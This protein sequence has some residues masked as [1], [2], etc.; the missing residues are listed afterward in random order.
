MITAQRL[1][2]EELREALTP[3]LT[4]ALASTN[5]I[6]SIAPFHKKVAERDD[7]AVLDGVEKLLVR[8]ADKRPAAV[9]LVSSPQAPGLVARG[10]QRA[11]EAKMLLGPQLGQVIL[12]PLCE[13]DVAGLTYTVLPYCKP[14]SNSKLRAMMQRRRLRPVVLTWLRDATALTAAE[15]SSDRVEA[16]F[17][18]PLRRLAGDAELPSELRALGR[19]ASA[20]LESGGFSPR[21]VLMHNDLWLGNILI[22]DR[23]V[24]GRAG[25]AWEER[26][27]IIDWPGAVIEG[28][29]FY[30]L[31]RFAQTIK[32]AGD[33]LRRE[34]RAHCGILGCEPRD[35]RS[36][37]AAALGCLLIHLEHFPK[38]AFARTAMGCLQ[39][40]ESV[41]PPVTS[42]RHA[43]SRSG[44]E[45]A[46]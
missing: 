21:H 8:G 41:E 32:L 38:P 34:V 46:A 5:G 27:V 23:N 4:A 16:S 17:G 20:R 1:P 43:L 19:D 13:G 15:P 25:R 18:Q 40:L 9:V 2:F 24:T 12:S 6:G 33:S 22:D 45:V 29:G 36:H 28:Y 31:L 14:L 26:F 37:L 10:M 42:T 35:A 11:R 39:L 44:T 7:L 30:D 3:T